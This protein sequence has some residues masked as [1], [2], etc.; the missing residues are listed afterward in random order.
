MKQEKINKMPMVNW[1]DIGQLA[2]TG[3]KMIFSTLIGKQSDK[4]II[5]ALSSA[6]KEFYDY[7]FFYNDKG[8]KSEIDRSRPRREIWLDYISDTGDGWNPTY[9]VAY[10]ASNP[11]LELNNNGSIIKTKRG[12]VLVFGGDEVYPTP[13]KEA[14]EKKLII[15]F[16]TAFGDDKPESRPHVFAIPG[17]H[18]WY[19]G[20]EA[21]SK[22]FSSDLDR[23]FAGWYTMQRRSYFALKLPSGWWLL[24]SDGQLQSNIDT[25]QIDYFRNV[26]EMHM[27]TGDKVILCISQPNWIYAYKYKKY[28]ELYDES[29]LIYLQNEILAK[30]DV[31][32]KVFLSGDYHHYRR[33][34]EVR[35]KDENAKVQKIT[36]GGGGAFLHSTNDIDVSLITED[37][38]KDKKSNRRFALR[39]S[40][41]E[42]ET[43]KKLVYRDLLFLFLNPGFGILTAIIYLLTAWIVGA[44]LHYEAPASFIQ[45]FILTAKAL[46]DNPFVAIWI[47]IIFS[48][49]IMFTDTHSKI[50]KWGG[51]FLH[52]FAHMISI[53]YIGWGS[54]YLSTLLF[55][56][57][58]L[59]QFV[60]AFILIFVLG[61]IIGSVIVGIYFFISM[62]FFGRHNEEAF[63]ALKIQD[64]KNFLRLHISE[65]GTLTIYP[66]KIEK[67]PRKWRNR[68]IK[69]ESKIRSYIVPADGSG[70][71]LIEEPIV[72][73]NN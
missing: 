4:R 3:I 13:S 72:L 64:Y 48:A 68:N 9:A 23:T 44:T 60:F 51:G 22:V 67:V 31:E 65:N 17:N 39:K 1:F 47:F 62:Y 53:F 26:A 36:A 71:E 43:S 12:E 5:Q 30:K 27:K 32:V 59:F 55:G 41:P 56:R 8:D 2:D 15:P 46:K 54:L 37:Y 16:E 19:D 52:C 50:Y 63:S 6:K 33:H 73:K 34:E 14:Y 21:F 49:F 69:H 25:P 18:D 29:D 38:G 7:S 66:I 57:D 42:I 10:H 70:A 20:L 24:G 35:P 28:N 45:T 40:F 61:W 58:T 11:E